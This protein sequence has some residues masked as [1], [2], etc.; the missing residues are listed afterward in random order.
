MKHLVQTLSQASDAAFAIDDDF[1]IIY[2]NEAAG[3]VLGFTAEQATGRYCY[4]LLGGRDENGRTVCQRFCPIAL[5]ALGGRIPP[6][7]DIYARATVSEGRWVNLSTFVYPTDNPGAG[8]VIV[9]LFRDATRKKS[10]ERFIDEIIET[11]RKL[12]EENDFAFTPAE[13]NRSPFDAPLDTLTA[14]ER[15]VLLL[16]ARGLGTK[17]IA[18]S[19]T[20]SHSTTRNHINNI[21]SK[22]GVHSRLEAVAQLYQNGEI[23]V[24]D[25]DE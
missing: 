4:E 18:N 13:S 1:R 17:E 23:Q 22:L 2:W 7:R 6:N 15:Q 24:P 12:L 21:L 8:K 16:L 25:R 14:R 5:N 9:H 20:I 11:S 19:L 3:S 10:S